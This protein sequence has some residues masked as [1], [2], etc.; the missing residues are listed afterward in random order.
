MKIKFSVVF[1]FCA[2]FY[3][4]C[5]FAQI[6]SGGTPLF[7]SSL[8]SK[9]AN[10][11]EVLNYIPNMALSKQQ[12]SMPKHESITFAHA[13]NVNY[14]PD[15]SG[16]WSIVDGYRVWHLEIASPG[17]YS[18][19]L[20]FDRY[21]LPEGAK[22]FLYSKDLSYIRGA[23]TSENNKKNGVLATSPIAGDTIVIEY[24][25]PLDADFEGEL[26]IGAVNHD[27]VG[28]LK[29]GDAG[30]FGSSG[31]CN[32]DVKCSKLA[33]VE[34]IKRGVLRM[35]VNGIEYCT[36]TL[37]NNTS[38]TKLP[39]VITAAHCFTDDPFND[40]TVYLF[41]Y[42]TTDCGSNIEG[43]KT[44]TI[45]VYSNIPSES[46][47]GADLKC[48]VNSKDYA[49]LELSTVPPQSYSPYYVGWS[50]VEQPSA[51]FSAIHHPNGDVKKISTA[52][53]PLY[54]TSFNTPTFDYDM[55]WQVE[56]W[57]TGTTEGGSSGGGLFDA[58][59]LLVGTLS[60]GA[61][62]CNN[63]VNDFYVRFNRAW[64]ASSALSDQLRTYLD[65]E[66]TGKQSL[67]GVDPYG[68]DSSITPTPGGDIITV[69]PNPFTTNTIYICSEEYLVEHYELYSINGQ[70]LDSGEIGLKGCDIKLDL[71]SLP[72]G[73]YILKLYTD[74]KT[75]TLKILKQAA[76]N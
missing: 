51:P 22:L 59:N 58:N 66:N 55:H 37:I 24:Q 16:N 18:I 45:G 28:V 67:Y 30:D 50:L 9:S 2:I 70:K 54:K 40:N 44:M 56:E 13:F 5:I 71:P 38:D 57:D 68:S 8:K 73:L 64:D 49:L 14:T 76:L 41:N 74:S 63:S 7:G 23:F 34:D 20:I 17:A 61:A 29:L 27:Y 36:A 42:E 32:V 60:G 62:S 46:V 72:T 15:N 21:V 69:N 26:L 43:D 53:N 12:A 19:N 75:F 6:T 48:I 1:L 47:S 25:E 3:P 65:P 52:I 4:S 33:G 39:Y 10:D 11:L 31:D 35:I